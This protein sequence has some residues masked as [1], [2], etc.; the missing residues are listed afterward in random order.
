M[1]SPLAVGVMV[2]VPP[3]TTD[4]ELLW[5]P[6]PLSWRLVRFLLQLCELACVIIALLCSPE[7]RPLPVLPSSSFVTRPLRLFRV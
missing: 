4:F 3:V 6:V 5:R 7:K 2:A 1:W